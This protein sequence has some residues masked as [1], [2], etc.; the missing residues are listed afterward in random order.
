[1]DVMFKFYKNSIL[2]KKNIQHQSFQES[3]TEGEPYNDPELE[4]KLNPELSPSPCTGPQPNLEP[5]PSPES[6]PKPVH[7]PELEHEP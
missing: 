6:E 4:S 2:S 3:K 7:E 5:E 1:M